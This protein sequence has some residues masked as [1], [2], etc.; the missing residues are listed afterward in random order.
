MGILGLVCLRVVVSDNAAAR[1]STNLRFVRFRVNVTNNRMP[2]IP[3][4]LRAHFACLSFMRV[5]CGM[6][7]RRL[8]PAP[9]PFPSR[10]LRVLPPLG[11]YGKGS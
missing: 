2:T 7:Q 11:Q 8:N 1:I 10:R 9:K 3:Q 6:F 5:A 4:C